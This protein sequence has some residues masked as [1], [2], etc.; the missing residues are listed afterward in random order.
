MYGNLNFD[1]W[2]SGLTFKKKNILNILR[3]QIRKVEDGANFDV[4]N[5]INVDC[6]DK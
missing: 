6:E 5:T 4:N 3:K 1:L 2:S